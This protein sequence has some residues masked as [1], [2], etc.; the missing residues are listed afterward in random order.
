MFYVVAP[1][2]LVW[3]ACQCTWSAT[4]RAVLKDIGASRRIAASRAQAAGAVVY[5]N[6]HAARDTVH[7]TQRR[8]GHAGGAPKEANKRGRAEKMGARRA[9]G[10]L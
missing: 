5:S 10:D 3:I 2:P 7:V 8:G 9:R 1:M 4:S 6:S